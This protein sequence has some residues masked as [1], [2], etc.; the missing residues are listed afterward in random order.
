M[1]DWQ[2]KLIEENIDGFDFEKIRDQRELQSI[3][4]VAIKKAEKKRKE[5]S[6]KSAIA[7]GFQSGV[8]I[9]N[10]DGTQREIVKT[11]SSDGHLVLEGRKGSFN[12]C[13]WRIVG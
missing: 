3:I 4:R 10:L 1:K 7:K 6:L 12:I 13:G 8:L 2:R 5:E 11:V 9:E